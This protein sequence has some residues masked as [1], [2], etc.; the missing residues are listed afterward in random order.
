VESADRREP[1]QPGVQRASRNRLMKPS[2]H[3]S[4]GVLDGSPETVGGQR[5]E[6]DARRVLAPWQRRDAEMT[7][8]RATVA[9][10]NPSPRGVSTAGGDSLPA[11]D[12]TSGSEHRQ[13]GAFGRAESF[14]K[15]CFRCLDVHE[16]VVAWSGGCVAAGCA[17]CGMPAVAF[18]DFRRRRQPSF[19]F[20]SSGRVWN[21]SMAVSWTLKVFREG[22]ASCGGPICAASVQ[23][24]HKRF[25]GPDRRGDWA[26]REGLVRPAV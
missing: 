5:L 10:R 11:A 2:G 12:W 3:V 1:V 18:D 15:D 19:G 20:I 24:A 21:R 14:G 23:R 26:R 22:L 7:T 9:T 8:T 25:A 4:S 16:K 13:G 6:N 17:S